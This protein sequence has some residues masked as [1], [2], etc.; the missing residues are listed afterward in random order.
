MGTPAWRAEHLLNEEQ[1]GPYCPMFAKVILPAGAA[2]DVH[3]HHGETETYYILTGQGVYDD[4]GSTCEVGPGDVT[5][6]DDGGSHGLK[7]TGDTDMECLA[8]IIKK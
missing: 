4:N 8:V 1:R 2:V 6:C 3:S 7:N 5:F